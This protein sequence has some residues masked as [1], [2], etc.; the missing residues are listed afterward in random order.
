MPNHCDSQLISFKEMSD[1]LE[2][3]FNET[4]SKECTEAVDLKTSEIDDLLADQIN[5]TKELYD[6][7]LKIKALEE[8]I[9]VLEGQC[10][11]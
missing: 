3:K 7:D 5:K 1:N 4:K 8:R 11:E 9:K 10:Q 2:K 6:K